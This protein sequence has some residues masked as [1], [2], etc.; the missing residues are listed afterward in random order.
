MTYIIQIHRDTA[1]N[2]TS[3]NPTPAQGEWCLETDTLKVKIGDGETAWTSL[4]YFG[5]GDVTSVNGETGAVTVTEVSGITVSGTPSSGQVLTATS[6]TAADWATPAA[7]PVSSVFGRTGA[8]VAE[9]GDYTAAEVGALATANNLSDLAD[10]AMARTNLGLG[11]AATEAST[12]FDAA[13][14]ASTAQSNAEASAASLYVPL[15]DLPVS[16]ANGGTGQT[17]AS[18]ALSA[19]GGAALAGATFTGAVTHSG[20]L[21]VATDA[22]TVDNMSAPATPSSAVAVW[23][24]AGH[25]NTVGVDG[26]QF[27][28]E[29]QSQYLTSA[30]S[31][32]STTATTIFTVSMAA[33][34]RYRIHGKIIFLPSGTTGSAN[35]QVAAPDALGTLV[36]TVKETLGYAESSG[37]SQAAAITNG[38]GEIL[39]SRLYTFT[40]STFTTTYHVLDFDGIM[41]N[42]STA[43]SVPIHMQ[44]G[45]SGDSSISVAIGSFID[46]MPVT[47]S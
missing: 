16:I 43:Q 45:A 25:L 13:G 6:S 7:A 24:S 40:T 32:S 14:A 17:T 20:G 37:N 22:L 21:T 15:T 42:S 9:S 19:L 5:S 31:V 33:S 2:W 29:R 10:A 26:N 27:D 18:A 35:L 30:I 46:L 47:V 3:V 34:A 4:A 38:N 1:A 36:L 12:A 39:T 44:L 11:T 28:T 23:A 41:T 8:V